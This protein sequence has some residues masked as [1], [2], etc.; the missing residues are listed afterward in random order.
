MITAE[1][2]R[3]FT[4]VAGARSLAAAAR[5]LNVSPPAVSQRLRALEERLGVQLVNRS[6]R[7]LTLSDEGELLADRG[8]RVLGS[9]EELEDAFADRRGQVTGHLRIVAP[10]GFGRRHVAGVVAAFHAAHPQVVV[11]LQLSDRLGRVPADAWDLTVHVGE[12]KDLTP[13][14]SQRTLAPNRRILCAAPGYLARHPAPRT[15]EDLPQHACIALRENDEDVTL[16]RFGVRGGRDSRVRIEPSLASNDGEVVRAWAL[17]GLGI[18]IRSEWDV[19]DD[20]RAGRLVPLLD[21]HPLPDAPVVVLFG[22]RRQARANRA[23]LFVEALAAALSPP[24]WRTPPKR[25]S[26]R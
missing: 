6:G 12:G 25:P 5:E 18:I 16:W 17:A 15:P 24:P 9:L 22:A 3:F 11:D 21:A 20:L 7:V 10:L 2:L 4:A 13:S 1:D 8:L 19:A 14:L 26:R 23:Q